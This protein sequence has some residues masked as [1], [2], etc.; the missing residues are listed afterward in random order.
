MTEF[1]Y[2]FFRKVHAKLR[3]QY[4]DI[5]YPNWANY[6]TSFQNPFPG[7]STSLM[8]SDQVT[9]DTHPTVSEHHRIRSEFADFAVKIVFLVGQ[10]NNDTQQRIVTESEKYG[11]LIQESF[12]DSYNNLTLKTIMMLKWVSLNCGD[13]GKYARYHIV[14]NPSH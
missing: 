2:S 9:T 3:G 6:T 4:L 14:H 8:A 12:L 7:P 11:D 10:T 13:K 1:N 5:N